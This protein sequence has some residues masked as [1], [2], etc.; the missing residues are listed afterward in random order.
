MNK[1]VLKQMGHKAFLVFLCFISLFC[2]L[3]LIA[4]DGQ[5]YSLDELRAT[6]D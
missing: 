6:L 5:K 3:P 4:D 1:F 2:Y